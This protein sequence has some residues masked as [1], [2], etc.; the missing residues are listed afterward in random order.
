MYI[1]VKKKTQTCVAKKKSVIQIKAALWEKV[2]LFYAYKC[3][4]VYIS[5]ITLKSSSVLNNLYEENTKSKTIPGL[6][7]VWL[8][9]S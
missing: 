8:S 1:R 6:L 5:K 4:P 9:P 7:N 3:F 2:C